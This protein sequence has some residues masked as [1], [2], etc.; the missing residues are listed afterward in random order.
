MSYKKGRSDTGTAFFLPF[1]ELLF[2]Y[3]FVKE[4][5]NFTVHL[6]NENNA[7]PVILNELDKDRLT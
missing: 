1:R 4:N 2:C 3:D 7:L 5:I 6:T